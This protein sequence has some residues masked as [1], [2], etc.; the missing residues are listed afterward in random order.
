MRPTVTHFHLPLRAGIIELLLYLL[1]CAL[2]TRDYDYG[3][4]SR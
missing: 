3:I 1:F 2:F 4:K